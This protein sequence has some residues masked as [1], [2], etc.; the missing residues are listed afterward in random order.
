MC[1]NDWRIGRLIRTNLIFYSAGS[2]VT[3]IIPQN[4]QRVGLTIYVQDSDVSER[5]TG[6]LNEPTSTLAIA[7]LDSIVGRYDWNI[8]MH[9]DFPTRSYQL[10]CEV[11][12][13]GNVSVVEYIAP[14]EYLAAALEQFRTEYGMKG[15]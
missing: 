1:F 13:T 14:E 6:T 4:S 5:V 12:N 2:P 7:L 9:G 3:F 15:Y 8:A 10:V 11:G